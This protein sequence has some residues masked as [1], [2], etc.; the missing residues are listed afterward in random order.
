[1]KITG[2]RGCAGLALVSLAMGLV[3]AA[4]AEPNAKQPPSPWAALVEEIVPDDAPARPPFQL[5]RYDL[6]IRWREKSEPSAAAMSLHAAARQERLQRLWNQIRNE[7]PA[8]GS[9][10]QR[11]EERLLSYALGESA[12][13]EALQAAQKAGPEAQFRLARLLL[14]ECRFDEAMKLLAT[15]V[16]H[17]RK[18]A[19]TVPVPA[20]LAA[21]TLLAR[22]D[23]ERS[24]LAAN[25]PLVPLAFDLPGFLKRQGNDPAR[26]SLIAAAR[27]TVVIRLPAGL[28]TQR[29]EIGEIEDQPPAELD[30]DRTLSLSLEVPCRFAPE[31]NNPWDQAILHDAQ[32]LYLATGGPEFALFHESN[33]PLENRHTR[34]TLR[35]E[36]NGPIHFRLYRFTA[37]TD[38]EQAGA[39]LLTTM[40]PE[41]FWTH[42]YQP[43]EQNN[44]GAKS[45]PVE[46]E[47][48][49][50]GYYLLTAEARYSP[51]LAGCKFILSN[52]ALY[53]RAGP[54]QA[55]AVAVDRNSGRPVAGLNLRLQVHT[56]PDESAIVAQAR[57]TDE[58]AFLLGFHG[59]R[60]AELYQSGA[61]V[62]EKKA[63][64]SALDRAEHDNPFGDEPA[65]KVAETSGPDPFGEEPGTGQLKPIDE[66]LMPPA[67]AVVAAKSYALGVE[68]RR[69]WPDERKEYSLRT[70]DD[71]RAVV[72][73]DLSRQ[74]YHYE[75]DVQRTDQKDVGLPSHV[76]LSYKPTKTERNQPRTILWLAQPV[77]RPGEMVEFAGL[78]RQFAGNRLADYGTNLASPPQE[79][80]VAVNSREGKIWQGLCEVSPAGTFHGRFRIPSQAGNSPCRFSVDGNST[81]PQI[82]L[83]IDEF[84][85]NT[86]NVRLTLPQHKCAAGEWA[87][88]EAS[89]TYFTGKVAAGAEVEV[90]AEMNDPQLPRVVG[91]TDSDGVFH[92]RLPIPK[93][94]LSRHVTLRAT[95]TDVS[96]QS[97]TASDWFIVEA[98]AF[99]VETIA[100]QQSAVAGT[101]VPLEVRATRW[102]DRPVVGATVTVVGSPQVAVTD[103]NGRA[104]VNWKVVKDRELVSVTVVAGGKAVHDTCRVSLCENPADRDAPPLEIIAWNV[105]ARI[106]AGEP[107]PCTLKFKGGKHGSAT[108]I[109]FLESDRILASRVFALPPGEHK[110]TIPT[111]KDWA[112]SVKVVV[113]VVDGD[114]MQ[115]MIASSYLH[116]TEKLLAIQVETDKAEYRPGERCTAVLTAR[117][118]R[119]RPV[120]RAAISLGVVDQ[121]VYQMREDP[122][123][124]LFQTLYEYAIDDPCSGIF[125]TI[126]PHTESV[127]FLRGPRYAWGYYPSLLGHGGRHSYIAC[128]GGTKHSE[129]SRELTVRRRFETAAHW[130]ADVFTT[131]DGTAR[132]TF[133]LPDN[134]TQWRF[135]AR[136][137][138]ADTL[139]GSICV[140]RR[141]FLPLN[142]ELA[143]PRAFREGDRFDLPVVVHNNTA[144]ARKVQC[145]TRIARQSEKLPSPSGRGPWSERFLPPGRDIAFT[146][147]VAV[148]GC[149][150][151]ELFASVREINGP[152]D[153][154]RRQLVPLPRN[155]LMTRRW[156]GLIDAERP[157]RQMCN[158]RAERAAELSLSVRRESGLAGPVQSALDEL[159]QYPYGCVEQTMSRFMPAVV[160]GAVM[161]EVGLENPAANRLADVIASGLAR[162]ADFQHANGGWGWWKEDVTNDFMTAYVVEGLAR[163]QRLKQPIPEAMFRRAYQ[164]LLSQV[165]EQLLRGQRPESIGDVDLEIY[166]VHALAETIGTDDLHSTRS[167]VT[168]ALPLLAELPGNIE[169]IHAAAAHIAAKPLPPR[170][171][172]RLLLADTWRLMGDRSKALAG[173]NQIMRTVTPRAHDRQS[174]IAAAALL[175][176]GAVLEPKDPR[177]ELL[178]RQIVALRQGTGWGDTLTTSAAVRGLSAVLA[179]PPAHETPITVFVDDRKIGELTAAHGNRIQLQIARVGT[180]VLQPVAGSCRDFY[181]IEVQGRCETPPV[182]PAVPLVTLHAR[183]FQSEPLLKELEPDAGGR[184]TIVHGKTYELQLEIE[185]KQAVSHARL[186]YP[187]PCGVELVRLPP[188]EDGLVSIESRDDAV[189]FFIER[190]LAGRHTIV[191]PIRA[192]VSGIVSSPPPE[193]VPMYGDSPPTVAIG[194]RQFV[195]GTETK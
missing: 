113:V 10:K 84:R 180:V 63:K 156:S 31:A 58:K 87:K 141:T 92:F 94:E 179:T 35:S 3:A 52:V 15:I 185:L 24:S 25:Q 17:D 55:I 4:A 44:H 190:W 149:Q 106:A 83:V 66:V 161:H 56:M 125:E 41:R 119:G 175:E 129:R 181:T 16:D 182:S 133:R 134:I 22:H 54:N 128:G 147:P 74:D 33:Q 165:Q 21:L 188:Q 144:V 104:H 19:G 164:Y 82:P 107:L 139:V 101:I 23:A 85:L 176:L 60:G 80:K 171:L 7:N 43:L 81:L 96:G 172:D 26:Q 78:L 142:V 72:D 178:A 183:F 29:I 93:S 194:P 132:I 79:V 9:P 57:P 6:G 186:T 122:L 169:V 97:Y 158:L 77:H 65:A 34:L 135:T 174:I 167:S 102:D 70:G 191:F 12:L 20:T 59:E 123:P 14:A 67:R 124:D 140:T 130:V 159:V 153:A 45:S 18:V 177:W 155:P 160:A 154:I 110:I 86:F 111:E 193:L 109:L 71:G 137:V 162:L 189:H 8:A 115:N 166:S 37:R 48:L 73:L 68:A 136:G 116:P 28:N 170:I 187:R 46:L 195:V 75:L 103:R 91:T 168:R 1:M 105:P 163:C 27:Q 121:A 95:V 64:P 5:G 76:S 131:A 53:L 117:D 13:D 49:G 192:E 152:A 108:V 150:P 145:M 11:A 157:T 114:N 2:L 184:L 47:N 99:H 69:R 30:V 40:K 120:P 36:F 112:P 50:E 42:E 88:G 126:E 38:W 127:Q 148:V 51:L 100:S 90:V 173:L 62:D 143:V 151:L 39:A 98:A 146:V 89:V 118:Y 138:T 32:R 61:A